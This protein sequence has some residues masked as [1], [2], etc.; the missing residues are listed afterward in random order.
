[1]MLKNS[2]S[3]IISCLL[4]LACTATPNANK[5][6][7]QSSSDVPPIICDI[8]TQFICIAAG[9]LRISLSDGTNRRIWSFIDAD[10]KSEFKVSEAK[11]CSDFASSVTIVKVKSPRL[12]GYG[13]NLADKY[14]VKGA[15]G[16]NIDVIYRK[17]I[18]Q[19]PSYSETLSKSQ[20]L[21]C[22]GWR[23]DSCI[24]RFD[25]G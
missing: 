17:G 24:Q 23:D 18:E 16:C 15:S 9:N 25:L 7:T 10:T 6:A 20:I 5:D 3:L 13:N 19:N 14:I 21:F 12:A 4:L 2:L 8:R 1:M 11:N 22:R